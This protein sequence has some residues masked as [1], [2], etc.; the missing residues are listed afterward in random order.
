[1]VWRSR[2]GGIDGWHSEPAFNWRDVPCSY[3]DYTTAR[4]IATD[5]K[6]LSARIRDGEDLEVTL[7]A[8]HPLGR[9]EELLT[10]AIHSDD[11]F[12]DAEAPL[13]EQEE[14][15][16]QAPDVVVEVFDGTRFLLDNRELRNHRWVTVGQGGIVP[17][18]SPSVISV[19]SFKLDSLAGDPAEV[20][21]RLQDPA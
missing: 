15:V 1:M 8:V 16:V 14:F 19:V 11:F 9:P 4:G 10:A 17:R 6:E 20:R 18:R 21:V 5:V 3:D 13:P 2:L 12:G 7:R